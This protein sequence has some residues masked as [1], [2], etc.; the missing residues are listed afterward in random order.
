MKLE[1]YVVKLGFRFTSLY[2][3]IFCINF[4]PNFWKGFCCLAQN[5]KPSPSLETSKSSHAFRSSQK[6]KRERIFEKG[7][8]GEVREVGSETEIVGERGRKRE[9]GREIE[10]RMT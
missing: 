4:R 9:I 6:E 1:K 5:L 2:L 7:R 10:K 8:E 3:L